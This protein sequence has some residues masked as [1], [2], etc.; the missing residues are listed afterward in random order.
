M[1]PR[2]LLTLVAI[3][4][5]G[6]GAW[7]GMRAVG[8]AAP[9]VAVGAP[10][11]DFKAVEI[12]GSGATKTIADYKGDVVLLNLWATWCVPCV[13]EMPSIQRLYDRYRDQ[14]FRVVGVAVDDPPFAERVAQFVRDRNLT[15]EILH[16]GSGKIE[17][18][19]RSR[20]IP[21]TYIVGRDGRIRVIRQGATDWD[22]EA[23]RAVIEQLLRR[24][25][26]EGARPTP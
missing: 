20:G 18:D 22:S 10:A 7:L 21:A 5:V 12:G 1:Q 3:T 2:G 26:A 24:E 16:E 25:T 14:G 9:V 11:P 13:T 23:S 17:Q 19:Y 6:A 15:F 4:V 8:N